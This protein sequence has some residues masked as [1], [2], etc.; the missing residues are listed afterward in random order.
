MKFEQEKNTIFITSYLFN[1]ALFSSSQAILNIQYKISG[2]GIYFWKVKQQAD[3]AGFV[4]IK[5]FLIFPSPEIFFTQPLWDPD[6]NMNIDR[7][8]LQQGNI[9]VFSI[10][11]KGLLCLLVKC[12]PLC[13]A[14]LGKERNPDKTHDKV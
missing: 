8:Y 4:K 6:V 5:Y 11:L 1:N 12:L 14:V 10:D 3:F 9:S 2:K 7:N 13:W